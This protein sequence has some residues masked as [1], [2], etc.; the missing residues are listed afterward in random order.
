MRDVQLGDQAMSD[1]NE[2]VNENPKL[3][4]RIMRIIDE[5]RKTPFDGIGKPE[6]LKGNLSGQGASAMKTALF[7]K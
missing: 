5:C 4:C 3:L 7:T 2:W 1:L 6:P